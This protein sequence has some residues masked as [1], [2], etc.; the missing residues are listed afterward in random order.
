MIRNSNNN[1]FFFLNVIF[2]DLKFK[3]KKIFN[4]YRNNESV[5]LKSSV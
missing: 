1:V 3:K 2:N 4:N 5:M